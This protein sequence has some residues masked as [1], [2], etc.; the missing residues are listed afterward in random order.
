M[1]TIKFGVRQGS[2]LSPALFAIY[3]DD[4]D[5]ISAKLSPVCPAKC[6]ANSLLYGVRIYGKINLI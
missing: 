6:N 3:V 2:V 5:D 4:V 1:F